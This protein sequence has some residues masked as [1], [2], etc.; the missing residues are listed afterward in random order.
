MYQ[1]NKTTLKAEKKDL[2]KLLIAMRLVF[3]GW[4]YYKW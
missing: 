3:F 1:T 4:D 2:D